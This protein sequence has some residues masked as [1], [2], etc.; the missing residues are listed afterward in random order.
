M[1]VISMSQ[2]MPGETWARARREWQGKQFN[3]LTGGQP[4]ERMSLEEEE[5]ISEVIEKAKG[6]YK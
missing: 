5:Q 6:P 4:S 3:D 2:E 1:I